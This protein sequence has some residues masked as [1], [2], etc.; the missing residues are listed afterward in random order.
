M[1][2]GILRFAERKYASKGGWMQITSRKCKHS[3]TKWLLNYHISML[4][5]VILSLRFFFYQL[6]PLDT[7]WDQLCNTQHLR[8]GFW[9][10]IN[11]FGKNLYVADTFFEVLMMS[12]LES[13]HC[14]FSKFY[15]SQ[16]KKLSQNMFLTVNILLDLLLM[17]L[18][19]RK[20]I[21]TFRTVDVK[22]E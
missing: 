7:L 19:Q 1:V 18:S 5:S 16:T 3:Q 12:A 9:S 14:N 17:Q 20:Q 11:P 13:Y 4:F 15:A 21:R 6:Q 2:T 10:K 8:A 22:Y